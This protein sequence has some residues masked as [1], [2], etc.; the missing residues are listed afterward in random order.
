M[1]VILATVQRTT[2]IYFSSLPWGLVQNILSCALFCLVL[3]FPR[4]DICLIKLPGDPAI[5]QNTSSPVTF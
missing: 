5:N 3:K 1:K 2:Y 4:I